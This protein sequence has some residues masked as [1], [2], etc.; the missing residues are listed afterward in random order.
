[1]ANRPSQVRV[2]YYPAK[3]VDFGKSFF[4]DNAFWPL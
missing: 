1:M 4:T 2:A 3:L